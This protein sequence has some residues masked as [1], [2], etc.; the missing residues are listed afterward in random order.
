MASVPSVR[1]IALEAM[2]VGVVALGVN[3]GNSRKRRFP[4]VPRLFLKSVACASMHRLTSPSPPTLIRHTSHTAWLTSEDH[5][6]EIVLL[7]LETRQ[8]EI[9]PTLNPLLNETPH[10]VNPPLPLDRCR[11]QAPM[12]VSATK[13][14]GDTRRDIRRRRLKRRQS[15]KKRQGSRT[16]GE[17]PDRAQG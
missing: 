14:G 17:D 7:P 13:R 9:L 16:A 4:A 6:Q 3:K 15:W 2:H 5:Q 10:R 1:H 8:G 12:G 11:R